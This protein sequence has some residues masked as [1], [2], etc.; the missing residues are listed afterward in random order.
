MLLP[1]TIFLSYFGSLPF[2]MINLNV[3]YTE[4]TRSRKEAVVMAFGAALIELLQGIVA[5]IVFSRL[6]YIS[7]FEIIFRY[8]SI[9]VFI[10][11]AIYY[12]TKPKKAINLDHPEIKSSSK[13]FLKGLA[14]SSL[15]FMAIPFW[16]IILTMITSHISVD[17]HELNIG[18]FGLGAGVGGFL[19]SFTYILVGRKYLAK[20]AL[21]Y[22]YL[23]YGLAILFVVLALI[24]LIF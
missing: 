1:L 15:N 18:L 8:A 16:L 21:V 13:P 3:L 12:W 6:I 9:A 24:A 20:S 7:D 5:A 14:L 17:W 10:G 2:G 22:K 23:D 19:A 11:L 4:L